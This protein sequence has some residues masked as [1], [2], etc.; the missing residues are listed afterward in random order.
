MARADYRGADP[1]TDRKMIAKLITGAT[2]TSK[3]KAFRVSPH[4][5]GRNPG[6][7]NNRI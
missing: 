1:T 4:R 2:N 6:A 3:H 5:S 7:F